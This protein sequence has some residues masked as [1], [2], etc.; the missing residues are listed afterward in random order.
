[1]LQKCCVLQ[2][3]LTDRSTGRSDLQLNSGI[4]AREQR[5]LGQ[6]ESFAHGVR[7]CRQAGAKHLLLRDT[8][9]KPGQCIGGN[10][11]HGNGNLERQRLQLLQIRIG[12][13]IALLECIVVQLRSLLAGGL[14]LDQ[15]EFALAV[16][17]YLSIPAFDNGAGG[18]CCVHL[19]L[20]ALNGLG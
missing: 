3:Q 15:P 17:A 19:V 1:V 6:P 2:I 14:S 9:L 11:I 13:P 10:S 4:N 18:L 16:H 20:A 8:L 7:H 5:L 12:D